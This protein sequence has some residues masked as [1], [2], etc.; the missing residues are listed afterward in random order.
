M[1][2]PGAD[3]KAMHTIDIPFMFDNI[4]LDED[5]VGREPEHLAEARALAATMSEMLITYARTGNPNHAGLPEW[6]AYDLKNR[7]TMIWEK[8]PHIEK[9]PRGAER[10]FADGAH[11][12]QAGTPLP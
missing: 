12:H 10:V 5:Q 3:G 7:S 9:D 1:N 6:P 8:T 11:Y 4:G 2:F